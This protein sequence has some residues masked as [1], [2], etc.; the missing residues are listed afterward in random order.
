MALAM[1]TTY[2]CTRCGFTY[3]HADH[4]KVEEEGWAHWRTFCPRNQE[5]DML[6][7]SEED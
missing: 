7:D 1:I 6:S 2:R 3:S 4:G 5:D